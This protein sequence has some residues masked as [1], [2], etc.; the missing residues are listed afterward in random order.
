[1]THHSGAFALVD[2]EQPLLHRYSEADMVSSCGVQIVDS[3]RC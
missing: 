2:A 3:G 1:M